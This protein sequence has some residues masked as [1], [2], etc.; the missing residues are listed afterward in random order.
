MVK[1]NFEIPKMIKQSF[2]DL[3]RGRSAMDT[4]QALN[5]LF[6]Q[7]HTHIQNVLRTRFACYLSVLS[8]FWSHLKLVATMAT[9][10][11]KCHK[12]NLCVLWNMKLPF[13][14]IQPLVHLNIVYPDWPWHCKSQTFSLPS[15]GEPFAGDEM[16]DMLHKSCMLY[17]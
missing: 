14:W 7:V 12:C 3:M 8:P 9:W 6:I 5:K 4:F 11:W 16:W 2:K 1:V 13:Y 15:I 17:H 10:E